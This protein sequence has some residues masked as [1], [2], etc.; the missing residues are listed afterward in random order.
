MT[1]VIVHIDRLV[2]RGV[3]RADAAG[4]ARSL[5]AEMQRLMTTPGVAQGLAAQGDTPR[6]RAGRVQVGHGDTGR[7]AAGAIVRGLKP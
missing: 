1:R 2:L 6:V 3:D 5:E 4:L 7:A